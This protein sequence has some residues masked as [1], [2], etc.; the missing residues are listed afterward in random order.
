MGLVVLSLLVAA[1]LLLILL[2]HP[3]FYSYSFLSIY[4]TSHFSTS[5]Q[6]FS[7][8]AL[9][10]TCRP[11]SAFYLCWRSNICQNSPKPW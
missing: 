4:I 1:L 8:L 6:F 11:S 2:Y 5:T 3:L 7:I 10:V 9:A